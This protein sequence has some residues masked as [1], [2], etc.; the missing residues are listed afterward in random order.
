MFAVP[1]KRQLCPASF[2]SEVMGSEMMA[3]LQQ[4]KWCTTWH[5]CFIAASPLQVCAVR[6]YNH[7]YGQQTPSL[8]K[9]PPLFQP[10]TDICVVP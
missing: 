6:L 4:S 5:K 2:K 9:P 3:H 8:Q 7:I 10:H 1:G